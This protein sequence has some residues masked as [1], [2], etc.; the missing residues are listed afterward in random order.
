MQIIS[1]SNT[2]TWQFDLMVRWLCTTQSPVCTQ[3]SVPTWSR[4]LPYL[5]LFSSPEGV[6]FSIRMGDYN[7][8]ER[9]LPREGNNRSATRNLPDL[10]LPSPQD[11]PMVPTLSQF[12]SGHSSHYLKINLNMIFPYTSSFNNIV[13]DLLKA[14]SYGT[15][16]RP[17]LSCL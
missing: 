17:D 1:S 7:N 4:K 13:T 8:T 16:P 2:Y 15:R 5:D 10:L 14:L 9:G 11:L 6:G 12:K 3:N